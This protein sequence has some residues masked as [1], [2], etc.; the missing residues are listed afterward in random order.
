MSAVDVVA[1]L[2]LAGVGLFAFAMM[3]AERR[4]ESRQLASMRRRLRDR[5]R[6]AGE[7]A[8]D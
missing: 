2:A 5:A 8:D 1:V 3:R 4:D 6:K 7:S